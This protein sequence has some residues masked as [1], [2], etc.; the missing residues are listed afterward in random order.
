MNIAYVRVSTDEQNEDRQMIALQRYKVDKWFVEKVSAST[1]ER[2]RLQAMIEF[3]RS[4]D[5][6]LVT[7]FSRLAR[8]TADLLQ[9]VNTLREKDVHVISI[10]E[11]FD[12]T[13]AT[14][15]LML[16]MLAAIHEFERNIL[17]ERQREGIEAAKEKGVYQGRKKILPP[18][19]FETFLQTIRDGSRSKTEVAAQ[20]GVSRNTLNR[21]I[22][23]YEETAEY[24]EGFLDLFTKYLEGEINLPKFAREMG[25]SRREIGMLIQRRQAEMK[26]EKLSCEKTE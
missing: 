4:G 16:T 3:A 11:N 7:D 9:L 5:T 8:N 10:S 26:R 14:G 20:L 25:I 15:R 2:P 22:R 13:T 6:V 24:P 18:D 12:T 23:E 21:F 1:L 17:L 19:N